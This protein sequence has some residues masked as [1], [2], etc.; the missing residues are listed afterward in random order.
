MGVG[1][2]VI[3]RPLTVKPSVAREAAVPL[4]VVEAVAVLPCARLGI[5]PVVDEMSTPAFWAMSTMRALP[6]WETL[7]TVGNEPLVLKLTVAGVPRM[8]TVPLLEFQVRWVRSLTVK[9]RTPL[10]YTE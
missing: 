4:S 2:L 7:R 10:R 9:T 3:G 6:E 8:V 5:P 1:K